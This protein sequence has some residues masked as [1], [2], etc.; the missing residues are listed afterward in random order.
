MCWVS[1]ASF[2]LYSGTTMP[3]FSSRVGKMYI[4]LDSM[5]EIQ[6]K[7]AEKCLGIYIIVYAMFYLL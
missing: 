1:E 3:I 4:K 7:L 6:G 2:D 5:D